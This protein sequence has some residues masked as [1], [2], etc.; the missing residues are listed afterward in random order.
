L[1]RLQDGGQ[2]ALMRSIHD[3]DLG[4]FSVGNGLGRTINAVAEQMVNGHRR[5]YVVF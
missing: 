4:T 2:D 1:A 5:I 3:Q